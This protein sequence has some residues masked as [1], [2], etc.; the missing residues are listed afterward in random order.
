VHLAHPA[1]QL[2]PEDQTLNMET[3]IYRPGSV[4]K[5]KDW[6]SSQGKSEQEIVHWRDASCALKQMRNYNGHEGSND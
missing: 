4:S 5:K 3:L 2:P 6:I 1:E